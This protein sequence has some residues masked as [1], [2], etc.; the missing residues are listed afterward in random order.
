MLT[1]LK[2]QESIRKVVDYDKYNLNSREYVL[3]SAEGLV[4]F[5]IVSYFFYRSIMAFLLLT[6]LIG[7]YLKLK[8]KELAKK[9]KEELNMQFKDAVLAV[10][11]NQRAGYSV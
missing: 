3:Y 5:G 4:L 11:A 8:K 1:N 9:R 2:P 7:I 6:P 10:S